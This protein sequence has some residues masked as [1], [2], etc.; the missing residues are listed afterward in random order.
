MGTLH[1]DQHKC[2]ITSHSFL[3]RL[4]NV[5]ERSCRENHIAYIVLNNFIK[6][7]LSWN[8]AEKYCT[9]RRATDDNTTVHMY[10]ACWISK[11]INTNSEF[12]I[13]RVTPLANAPPS[14]SMNPQHYKTAHIMQLHVFPLGNLDLCK[15]QLLCFP[16]AL[17]LRCKLR[18]VIFIFQGAKF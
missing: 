6:S 15:S 8:N 5:S 14:V 7:C 4:T 10:T 17:I 13:G 9:G 1:E 16:N 3:L 12:V 18:S 2:L 11:A